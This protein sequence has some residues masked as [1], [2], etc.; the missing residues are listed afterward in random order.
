MKLKTYKKVQIEAKLDCSLPDSL[1]KTDEYQY[2]TF[3]KDR[4]DRGGVNVWEGLLV[5]ILTNLETEI[6]ETIFLEFNTSNKK[7]IIRFAYRPPKSS[8]KS[9]FFEELAKSLDIAVNS[10]DYT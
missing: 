10:F 1:F 9:L 8:N 4:V 6:S 3:R 5:N 2:P 7:L